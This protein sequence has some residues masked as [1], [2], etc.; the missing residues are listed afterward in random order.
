MYIYE[1]TLIFYTFVRLQKIYYF[2][3]KTYYILS[4]SLTI[5]STVI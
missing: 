1:K 2:H 3:E 4:F 5:I